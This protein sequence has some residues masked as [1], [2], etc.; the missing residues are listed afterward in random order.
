MIPCQYNILVYENRERTKCAVL[1]LERVFM[2]FVLLCYTLT[3]YEGLKHT[4]LR[5]IDRPLIGL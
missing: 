1:N 2:G 4:N 3:F 5:K